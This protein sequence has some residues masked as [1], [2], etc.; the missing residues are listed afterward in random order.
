MDF[1]YIPFSL[2]L[3][4]ITQLKVYESGGQ[5]NKNFTKKFL[6]PNHHDLYKKL[7]DLQIFK[8]DG[9]NDLNGIVF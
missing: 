8:R 2:T 5:M 6:N 7:L 9:Q 1:F 3:F 4:Q